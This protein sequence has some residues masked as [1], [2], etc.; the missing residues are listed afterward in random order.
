MVRFYFNFIDKR[1]NKFF[2]LLK[3]QFI[4]NFSK[5]MDISNHTI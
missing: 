2:S 1:P 3:I 4:I 5:I